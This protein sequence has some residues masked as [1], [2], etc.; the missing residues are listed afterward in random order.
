MSEA[1]NPIV[2][3]TILKNGWKLEYASQISTEEQTRGAWTLL[4]PRWH[5]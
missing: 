2:Y 1:T 3:G 5:W 4:C